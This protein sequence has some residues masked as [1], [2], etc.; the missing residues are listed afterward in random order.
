M[1]IEE[2]SKKL[3]LNLS[4]FSLEFNKL[5]SRSNLET[6]IANT[7]EIKENVIDTIVLSTFKSLSSEYHSPI[8]IIKLMNNVKI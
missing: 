8:K 3:I 4:R 5:I 2:L 6:G 1:N 7:M